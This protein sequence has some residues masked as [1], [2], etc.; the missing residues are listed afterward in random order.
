MAFK[1]PYLHPMDLHPAYVREIDNG[2]YKLFGREC[3]T[4]TMAAYERLHL[5]VRVQENGD[6]LV[7]WVVTTTLLHGDTTFGERLFAA[8]EALGWRRP[9]SPT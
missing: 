1:A 8:L 5:G 2:R 4:D 9:A 3:P 7:A 6:K